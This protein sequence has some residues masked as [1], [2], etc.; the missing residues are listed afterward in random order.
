MKLSKSFRTAFALDFKENADTKITS[1]SSARPTDIT[2]TQSTVASSTKKTTDFKDLLLYSMLTEKHGAT[3]VK[4]LNLE[5]LFDKLPKGS[6]DMK[7]PLDARNIKYMANKIAGK[8]P[9]T[10]ALAA[11]S[12]EAVEKGKVKT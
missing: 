8:S 7:G 3:A 1:P 2:G 9:T 12:K 4:D 10:Q 11:Y 5:N 6:F